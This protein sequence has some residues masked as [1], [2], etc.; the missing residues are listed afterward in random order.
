MQ[1]V[2]REILHPPTTPTHIQREQ[3]TSNNNNRYHKH[4]SSNKQAEQTHMPITYGTP[5][6]ANITKP[7]RPRRDHQRSY[8]SGAPRA[9]RASKP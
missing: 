4:S 5:E 6:I 9:K 2:P 1:L 7:D 3:Q 8:I